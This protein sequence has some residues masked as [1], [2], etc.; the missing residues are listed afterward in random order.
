MKENIK[1]WADYWKTFDLLIEKLR[2]GNRGQIISELKE[3]QKYVNGMT[4][5]WYD[6]MIEMEKIVESNKRNMTM[7]EVELTNDLI[8]YLRKLFSQS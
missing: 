4:D 3:A 5:G 1:S 2:E 7:E 6:F 8:E